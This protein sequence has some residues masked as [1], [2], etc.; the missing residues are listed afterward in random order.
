MFATRVLRQ[1]A[2]HAERVPSI[3][4]LGRRTIP[5]SI[6]HTPAPHPA[7]P[8]G[9]LPANFGN[10]SASPKH[11]SFSS[12]RDHA[13]QHGP[14]QRSISSGVGGASGHSLGSVV[15]PSGVAFDRSELPARFRRQPIDM[16][17]IEAV[18]SGGAALFG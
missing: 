4:F 1:A 18:E 16:A 3:R 7:S 8:T 17:E 11:T 9:K 14:L 15:P 12:Y 2:A 5:S 10:G 13:Q 6:D